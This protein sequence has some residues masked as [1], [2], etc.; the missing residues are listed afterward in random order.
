MTHSRPSWQ[1][2]RRPDHRM[3]RREHRPHIGHQIDSRRLT[4]WLWSVNGETVA[5]L[6]AWGG[7]DHAPSLIVHE[8]VR[9]DKVPRQST[10]TKVVHYQTTTVIAKP[11]PKQVA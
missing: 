4:L 9:Y 11:P 1:K 3:P 5:K 2:S 6:D 7:S 10:H 8:G